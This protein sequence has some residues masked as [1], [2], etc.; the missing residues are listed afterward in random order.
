MISEN[1]GKSISTKEVM[2]RLGVDDKPISR[3]YIYTLINVGILPKPG[4][5]GR[6]NAWYEADVEAART[7][8]MNPQ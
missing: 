7:K 6:V 4:K 3:A 5:S 1:K 8:M 2:K